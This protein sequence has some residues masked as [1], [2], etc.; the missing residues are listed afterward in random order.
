MDK[1]LQATASPDTL[2]SAPNSHSP[3]HPL[4]APLQGFWQLVHGPLAH[5]AQQRPDDIALR[6]ASMHYS[7]AALYAEV[8]TRSQRFAAQQLPATVLLNAEASAMERIV[9]F[10][11]IID[12]GRC[13]AVADPDWPAAVREQVPQWLPQEPCALQSAQPE[14]AFY[15]GFTSGSTGLPKGFMRHHRSWTESFRVGI[16]DFG[17]VAAQRTLAPGRMSHSLF[18]FGVM[19]ALWCGV[20]A[21]V[22]EQFSAGRSLALLAAGDI[23]CLVAVP[24]QL[25]VMLQLAQ[26]RQLPPIPEVQLIT[27][28]GARWMRA[29]TP[30]L[31]ALFPH[32]RIVEFYGASEASFIAWMDAGENAPAL[33]VG[34]PFSNVQLQI[35]KQQ[36]ADEDGLIFIQSPM[37]FMDYV[38]P[39]SSSAQPA[40]DMPSSIGVLRDGPWLSVRDMGHIDA[41]GLLHLAGRQSRMLVTQGKNLFPEEVENLLCSHPGIAKASLYGLPNALRGLE[42]HAVIELAPHD[43]TDDDDGKADTPAL[44]A[45]QLS[46]WLREQLE[47][48]KLPRHWWLCQ[49]WPMTASGKTDHGALQQALHQALTQSHSLAAESATESTAA[50]LAEPSE[51][52]PCGA[53]LTTWSA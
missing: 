42:I 27:I 15:T 25:M 3:A 35:R 24:S 12:S 50:S 18:L 34:R 38:G 44:H 41:S 26:R 14:S 7:F 46:Q 36:P 43:G 6:S 10:L 17:A 29:Q 47:A 49:H 11:A 48:Y 39:A 13:A 33:A 31:R 19:Q 52:S 45:A 21:V 1:P 23:P 28:S 51:Q 20:G 22:Q 40:P 37:L 4:A 2:Q 30:A 9:D 16:Q 8:Q 5:W 53:L 32:A